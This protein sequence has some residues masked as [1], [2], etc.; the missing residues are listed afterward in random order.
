MLD[1]LRNRWKEIPGAREQV[2]TIL[3]M[4]LLWQ[5]PALA[6]AWLRLNPQNLMQR[7]GARLQEE[8]R[9]DR[10]WWMLF[11]AVM[12]VLGFL[13]V[14]PA[15]EDDLLK[16]LVASLYHYNYHALYF[17]S[18]Y[19]MHGDPYIGM[20]WL[21]GWFYAHLSPRWAYVPFQAALII[22]FFAV[23]MRVYPRILK[24][25]PMRYAWSALLILLVWAQPEFMG[26]VLSARPE[27]DCALWAFAAVAVESNLEL[28]LWVL[29]GLAFIPTYWLTIVYFPAVLILRRPWKTRLAI[30]A[31]LSAAFALFWGFYTDGAWINWLLGLKADIARR[32]FV[33]AESQPMLQDIF[34]FAGVLWLVLAI[35]ALLVRKGQSAKGS[36]LIVPAGLG[37]LIAWFLIPNMVRYLDILMPLF[38]L[39]VAVWIRDALAQTSEESRN[40]RDTWIASVVLLGS[41]FWGGML[42]S[43]SSFEMM[44]VHIPGYHPGQKVLTP[45]GKFTYDVPYENPGIRVT[46]SME[47]GATLIPVQDAS[48][49][50]AAHG[51]VSCSMLNRY[52]I[53]YVVGQLSGKP[54]ACLQLLSIHPGV[55]V[56]ENRGGPD[57]AGHRVSDR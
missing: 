41:L 8:V 52:G 7:I 27:T 20:D 48:K 39:G 55:Q 16:H 17:A 19:L 28:A 9:K 45:F 44:P 5:V 47:A 21:S 10:W 29:V 25:A 14:H 32:Q 54:P 3:L 4:G 31:G 6:V 11:P 23:Q 43:P 49:E 18:P 13:R 51:L 15:P 40:I 53:R 46:P 26:K 33:V 35:W 12:I 38:S 22:G 2:E 57:E 24:D 37:W 56:W 42:I 34:S 36:G 50:L 1:R 30:F